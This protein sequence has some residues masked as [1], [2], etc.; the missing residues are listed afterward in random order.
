MKIGEALQHLT[1][2]GAR[3]VDELLHGTSTALP[4]TVRSSISL[5]AFTQSARS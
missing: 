1:H 3:G 5:K 4:T 2:D